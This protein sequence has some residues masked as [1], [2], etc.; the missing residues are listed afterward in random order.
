MDTTRWY[1]MVFTGQ[2]KRIYDLGKAGFKCQADVS[3]DSWSEV[4][5]RRTVE[6]AVKVYAPPA[7]FIVRL[8]AGE[9]EV[10]AYA[11]FHRSVFESK[12]MTADWRLRTL[13]HPDYRPDLDIEGES[14][15]GRLAALCV[16]WLE[17][18]SWNEHSMDGRVEPSGCHKD[19]RRFSLGRVALSQGLHRLQSLGAQAIFVETDSY[20]NT[21]F[22]LYE[23]INFQ[24]IRDVLVYRKD[25][26]D[27]QK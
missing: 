20:R 21:V 3:E 7:G 24:V 22:R 11:E 26:E 13:R 17:A 23:S 4:L 14:P 10:E 27:P 12:N 9:K 25:F 2:N 19:F 18:H 16:C 15:D 6:T 8:L 1:V 5:L